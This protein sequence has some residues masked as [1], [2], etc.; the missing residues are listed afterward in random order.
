[1]LHPEAIP[2]ALATT[3]SSI[4]PRGLLT[5]GLAGLGLFVI[6]WLIVKGRGEQFP[7]GLGYLGYLSAL[8]LVVL[9]FARLIL[10]N[11]ANPLVLG[12][13]LVSGF[14]VNPLWYLWLGIV[15]LRNR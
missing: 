9:Y 10:L 4:D 15:L 14:L 3:P 13:A 5:F 11:P 8:L 7:S 6:A 12:T 2:T 1:V